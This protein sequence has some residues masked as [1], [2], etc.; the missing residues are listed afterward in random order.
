VTITP[1]FAKGKMPNPLG[2]GFLTNSK[3][4]FFIFFQLGVLENPHAGLIL[5]YSALK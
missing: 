4:T 2:Q 5:E 1:F 3:L